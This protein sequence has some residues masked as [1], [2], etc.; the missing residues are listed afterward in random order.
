MRR[1]YRTA[2]DCRP[3]RT[4]ACCFFRLSRRR[5][6]FKTGGVPRESVNGSARD[7]VVDARAHIRRPHIVASADE[8]LFDLKRAARCAFAQGV[9]GALMQRIGSFMTLG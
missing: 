5:L 2:G 7:C 1:R 3:P 4:D 9:V 8:M 6:G